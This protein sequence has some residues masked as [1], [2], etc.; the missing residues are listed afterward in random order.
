MHDFVG[1]GFNNFAM[2]MTIFTKKISQL[3]KVISIEW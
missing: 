2:N 3:I 1:E